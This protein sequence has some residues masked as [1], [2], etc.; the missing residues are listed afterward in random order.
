MRKFI[1]RCGSC[2]EAIYEDEVRYN[3][4]IGHTS[5]TLCWRCCDE[6]G[7]HEHRL[8]SFSTY[9][10]TEELK[11]RDGVSFDWV[12]PYRQSIFDV[13][14]PALMLKVID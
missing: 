6:E 7:D 4:N 9:D 13:D 8:K 2:G 3:V 11:T 10:L 1:G 14:G 5:M 12:S